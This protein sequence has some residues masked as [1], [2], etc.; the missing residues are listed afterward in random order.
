MRLR[1]LPVRLAAWHTVAVAVLLAVFCGGT[2]LFVTRT[3][4]ARADGALADLTRTFVD[5]WA[6]ERAEHTG[7]ADPARAAAA[8]VIREFRY[9]DQRVLVFDD[10]GQ[11]VA[12]SDSTPPASGHA[13]AAVVPGLFVRQVAAADAAAS[14]TA[15]IPGTGPHGS[16]GGATRARFTRV[17]VGRTPFVIAA[18]RSLRADAVALDAFGDALAVA[19]PIALVLAAAGGYALTRASLAPAV[20]MARRAAAIGEDT[21]GTRLPVRGPRD[22]LGELARVFNALLDRVEAAFGRQA[23]AAA[24]QRQFMADAS[25]ELRTPVTALTTVADVALARADRPAAELV[26][27]LDVVRG[28]GRRLGRIVDELLLLARAD[29]GQLPVHRKRLYLEEV[30]DASVRAARGLAGVRGV[31]LEAPL[32]DEAPFLGDPHLLRRLLANLLDNAIKY[33]S[34][35]G[36]VRVTLNRRAPDHTTA[37]ACYVITVD[38]TGCG[39]AAADQARVFERFYRADPA[40]TRDAHVRLAADHPGGA[41]LG[42]AIAQWIAAE[43]AGRVTLAASGP[44]GSRFVVTFPIPGEPPPAQA[45]LNSA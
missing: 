45:A 44:E 22:E 32:A 7:A 34:A 5:A 19:V 6:A 30:V 27:A 14:F 13:F 16:R 8:D 35:G 21:L 26:E 37:S 15:T 4:R 10:A 29:A 20:A 23:R 41:G 12:A 3:T 9:R 39:I 38:D 25:H 1:S 11:L 42:L 43:H 2:W 36:R 17:F 40:R 24:E 33:T 18:L 31:V 28:E